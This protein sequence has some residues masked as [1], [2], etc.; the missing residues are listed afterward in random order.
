MKFLLTVCVFLLTVSSSLS[1]NVTVTGTEGRGVDITCPYPEKE[2]YSY[3]YFYKG[4]YS[5]RTVKLESDGMDT[6]AMNGRFF[7][8]DNRKSSFTVT[9]S[10]LRM[11]DAGPYGCKAGHQYNNYRHIQLNVIKAPET[12]TSVQIST[13]TIHPFTTTS[14]DTSRAV[15]RDLA[16]VAV[17]LGSA[18]L[19]LALC[20]GTILIRKKRKRKSGTANNVQHN[21]EETDHMFEIPN[22]DFTAATSTSNQTPSYLNNDYTVYATATNQQP[23]SNLS[24]TY[25]TNQVTDTDYYANIKPPE[26]TQDSGTELINTTATHPQNITTDDDPLNAPRFVIN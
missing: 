21:T 24:H 10:H 4:S 15:R 5:E 22:T 26:A 9:I 23:D 17:G 12:T 18:L 1:D 6:F 25:L 19:V 16:S 3:K 7:L 13:S 2:K 11:E 20:C 8:K 14:S